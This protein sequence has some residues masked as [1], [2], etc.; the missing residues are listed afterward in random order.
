MYNYTK[1]GIS[2]SIYFDTRKSKNDG[3]FPI[4]IRVWSHRKIKFYPTG[5]S[6][7][8][9]QWKVLPKSRAPEL[10]VIRQDVEHSFDV[11]RQ[12]VR[13]LQFDGIFS[14]EE[15]DFRL[16]RGERVNL[17]E[18]LRA[19]ISEYENNGKLGTADVYKATLSSITS[20]KGKKIDFISVTP[21]WLKS[22][23]AF[24]R[25]RNNSPATIAIYMQNIRHAM[26]LAIRDKMLPPKQYPFGEGQYQIRLYKGRK[27]ALRK[28]DIAR[29]ANFKC[30][31]LPTERA[32]D[33]WMFIY[34]CNGV[35]PA[36]IIKLKFSNIINNEI[37]FIRQKTDATRRN[38]HEIV[39]PLTEP[40]QAIIDK[41]G[42]PP[43]PSNYIFP[44]LTPA[45][46]DPAV[47]YRKKC[48][49]NRTISKHM[50]KIGKE[51]GLGNVNVMVARHTFAST[52]YH[53]GVPVEFISEGMGHTSIE[54]TKN[55][56][57]SFSRETRMKN[58]EILRSAA[59]GE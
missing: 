50:K 35:N 56:L 46:R 54:T 29:I 39:V 4:K 37:Y 16:G 20:F 26:R 58:A 53:A 7:T 12:T 8:E 57:A 31:N 55:Y 36:D 28:E 6:V 24:C 22:F 38:L 5:K 1:D 48:N 10:V 42:N 23:E 19:L 14:F 27:K 41:W 44:V 17:N 18:S 45:D 21:S 25:D 47:I 34:Y 30:H 15:L 59:N 43:N 3:T 11:I 13:D 49:F 51:L 2:L 40:M 9:Q 33:I 32:R 52:L